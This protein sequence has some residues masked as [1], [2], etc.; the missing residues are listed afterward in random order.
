MTVH[1]C[2]KAETEVDQPVS[3]HTA[4]GLLGKS[5]LLAIATAV[6]A[7]GQF[8]VVWLFARQRGV[9]AL[10]EYSLV[11]SL[12]NLMQRIALSGLQ[13]LVM[14]GM[15]R[16]TEDPAGAAATSLAGVSGLGFVAAILL[17]LLA[18]LLDYPFPVKVALF[19]AC[20]TLI[21]ESVR[22]SVE[23]IGV[24]LGRIK[25]V[26]LV[27]CGTAVVQVLCV[28][29]AVLADGSLAMVLAAIAGV[30]VL[31]AAVYLGLLV[32]WMLPE[33]LHTSRSSLA[34]WGHSVVPFL[35][36]GAFGALARQLDVPILTEIGGFSAAGMYSAALKMVKPLVM[37]R[38]VL[39]QVF[40]PSYVRIADESV[41]R[42]IR[43]NRTAARLI[44]VI[45]GMVAIV[46]VVMARP[47][48]LFVYGADFLPAGMVLQV[49]IWG[50]PAFYGQMLASS[51][52]FVNN[53]EKVAARASLISLLVE[54]GLSLVLVP[55]MGAIGMAVVYVIVRVVGMLQMSFALSRRGVDLRFRHN[56]LV[57]IG[58]A[59]FLS[60]LCTLLVQSATFGVMVVA[61]VAGL[62]TY[63]VVLICLG[64]LKQDDALAIH[65]IVTGEMRQRR[66]WSVRE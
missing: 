12:V 65:R 25:S 34:D 51:A 55:R 44:T 35:G 63:V 33:K 32:R 58:L 42:G 10:G 29:L 4:R 20:V 23:W 45:L 60:L 38:P 46:G 36:G 59:A 13:P 24:S 54:I 8:L 61:A 1:D 11:I 9:V 14:R 18:Y 6:T 40:F 66:V 50:I 57:P 15:A 27:T 39:F 56:V 48:V 62:I 26:S 31:S 49:I 43:A 47:V 17:G 52:L 37:L 21:S 3:S 2:M 19:V 41:E 53:L 30:S 7:M 16:Q 28:G 22:A 64:L 5:G